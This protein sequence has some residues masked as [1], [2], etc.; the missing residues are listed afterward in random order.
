M[1][2]L[3]RLNTPRSLDLASSA[4]IFLA[5]SLPDGCTACVCD[6][7]VRRSLH[8]RFPQFAG[9]DVINAPTLTSEKYTLV[10]LTRPCPGNPLSPGSS[11][12]PSEKWFVKKGKKKEGKEKPTSRIFTPAIYVYYDLTIPRP[13]ARDITQAG[14]RGEREINTRGE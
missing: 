10:S 14:H 4:S 3:P 9:G 1:K 12:S 6:S 5:V 13:T 11:H 8:P 2:T 7:I